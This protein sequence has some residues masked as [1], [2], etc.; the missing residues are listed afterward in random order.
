MFGR[1]RPRLTF[2]NVTAMLA[3]CVALGGT[4]YAATQL[5][6]NSVGTR[7]LKKGS[8]T[9]S[10]VLDFSLRRRDFAPGQL[11]SGG[12]RG[13]AGPKGATGKTG[14]RGK[15]GAPGPQGPAGTA[16]AYGAV[17]PGGVLDA[18]VRKNATGVTHTPGTGAYCIQP[19]AGID[20]T[21]T[22]VTVTIAS[23]ATPAALGYWDRNRPDCPAG[24]FEVR[25]ARV[26][27]PPTPGDPATETA[28]EEPF[29]FTIP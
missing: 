19:A 22:G 25:T 16:R 5:P 12:A 2:A 3:L 29:F 21:T 4:G 13:P 14:K 10:K 18:N 6:K 15:T 1:L 9:S 8:V 26:Q 24:Q 27:S 7:Q 11:P 28:T 20:A 17:S 23:G